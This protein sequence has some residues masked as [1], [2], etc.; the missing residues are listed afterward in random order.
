MNFQSTLPAGTPELQRASAF[1]RERA[2]AYGHLSPTEARS[3]RLGLLGPSMMQDLLRFETPEGQS[4]L[5]EVLA[6]CIRHGR[7]LLVH[8]QLVDK[9]VPLTVFPRDWLVYCAMP[10]HQ[11]LATPLCDLQV[12]GVEP[13]QL[14][15]PGASS[16]AFV[17]DS[18]CLAPLGSFLWELALRG[19]RATL[20]PEI[21]GQ[22]AYR[23]APGANLRSLQLTGS[24][25]T[26]V[27]KLQRQTCNLAEIARWPSFNRERA[28]RLLN[29][30]YL[31]AGL[32]ISR[33][34][35][36]ATNEHWTSD[37]A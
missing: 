5:L 35:P 13:P 12:L 21:A 9:A 23:I 4:E 32:M 37:P 33:T 25:A 3:S 28:M 22:A 17:G 7:N 24:I 31:Q 36:A 6:A 15:A 29:A 11:L 19:S 2:S 16:K 34:H 18:K 8:L 1:R 20:L 26:A 27:D 10:M 30:L 14:A